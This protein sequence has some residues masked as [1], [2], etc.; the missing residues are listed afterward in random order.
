MKTIKLPRIP[1]LGY[2]NNLK[3]TWKLIIIVGVLVVASILASGFSFISIKS[4]GK[5]TKSLYYNNVQGIT[6]TALFRTSIAVVN[7]VA[8][9]LVNRGDKSRLSDIQ[10]N[11]NRMDA[12]IVSIIAKAKNIDPTVVESAE[13][14]NEAWEEIK[15]ILNALLK[16]PDSYIG[17][18]KG[19]ALLSKFYSLNL[20][21]DLLSSDM[22]KLGNQ[23]ID[24]AN[25]T[26]QKQSMSVL[27][28]QLI[29]IVLAALLVIIT[30]RSISRPLHSLRMAM[31][32][33]AQGNLVLPKLPPVHRDEIGETS[34]AYQ[35]SVQQLREMISI[36]T[37]VTGSLA[38]IA[39]DLSPQ[40]EAAGS[41]AE[42]VRITMNELVKGTQEEARAA[43][44]VSTTIYGVVNQ[45][46]QVDKKTQVI[47]SRSKEVISQAKQGEANSQTI[48]ERINELNESTGQATS[49]IRDLHEKSLHIEEI[50]GKIREITEQTQLLSLNASIEAA[51]AGEQGRGFAVVA[52]E[53]GKLSEKSGDSVEDVTRVLDNIRSMISEAVLVMDRSCNRA[54]EGQADIVETSQYFQEIFT[55]INKVAVEIQSVAADISELT[56]ANN[57]VLGEVNTI[58]AITEE[59]AAH[60]EEV[61]ATVDTQAA[62]FQALTSYMN[63]LNSFSEQLQSLVSRFHV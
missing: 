19:N 26:A 60:T 47:A 1:I 39:Q 23:A 28:Y 49:V 22:I 7:T 2:F 5:E 63:K 38:E 56:Q 40:I 6:D 48:L 17:S 45:I 42:T 44:D 43:D 36:V 24:K 34:Q 41:G 55:S 10:P 30:V 37:Q 35:Q 27:L 18:Q 32:G 20:D 58:A 14:V 15:S 46:N 52:Q 54:Q 4:W 3:T 29:T 11:I 51:R 59:T 16:E 61:L 12:Y 53:I 21:L 50:I 57:R 9:N 13:Y 31:V 25:N 8:A 33:L 62:S